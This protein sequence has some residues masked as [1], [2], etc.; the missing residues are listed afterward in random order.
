MLTHTRTRL[1]T[2]ILFLLALAPALEAST[3]Q[4]CS[5]GSKVKWPGR[6]L[7]VRASSVGFPSGSSWGN[8]L[9]DVIHGWRDTPSRMNYGLTYGDTSVGMNNG[10]S[11]TWWVASLGAPAICYTWWNGSCELVEADVVFLNTTPYTTS[12]RKADLWAYGGA[13]RP[14]RTTA[15]HEFG[16]AQGLLHTADTYSIMGQDWDHMHANGADAH[17]YPGEDAVEGSV[18][19][20]GTVS[21]TYN[22]LAVAHWR[23]TGASG[24][25]STHERTR[26]FSSSGALLP[27][28]GSSEPLYRV[29]PAQQIKVEFSFENLGKA[30]KTARVGYYLSSNDYISTSDTFLGAE[31]MT[32][33]RNTVYTTTSMTLTLPRTL[34]TNKR[35]WIGAIIDDNRKVGET[36]GDNNASYIPLWVD[37]VPPNLTAVS[38]KGP[39]S[40]RSGRNYK[41]KV[42]V[43][44]LAW[45][46]AYTFEVR[47]SDN[48]VISS[49][50]L[51]VASGST[52]YDGKYKIQ[53]RMPKL[54]KGKYHWGLILKPV[55]GEITTS[56]NTVLGGKMRVKR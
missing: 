18:A 29:K 15:M 38:I 10:Q 56:D 9:H 8:A 42:N 3:W 11:E 21:G 48:H 32:L 19:V 30:G 22:D 23:R 46:G 5:T 27:N 49:Y 35:Y 16:H 20:Y 43:E 24:A 40:V 6:Y 12:N 17:T 53:F 54:P 50:D 36:D 37:P 28:A 39:K 1:C 13:G 7:S 2:A 31:S 26:V 25:Y 51:L 45:S 52:S 4:T 41:V 14:F 34:D 44:K 33:Y 47:I 55:S